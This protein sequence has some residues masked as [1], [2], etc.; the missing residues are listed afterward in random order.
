MDLTVFSV[1]L[2]LDTDVLPPNEL[3]SMLDAA[4]LLELRQADHCA[5]LWSHQSWPIAVQS[6]R[7]HDRVSIL[8]QRQGYQELEC[9][10][11]RVADLKGLRE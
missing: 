1:I 7:C 9:P 5:H 6:C 4:C 2:P 8:F 11:Q 10:R 3:T